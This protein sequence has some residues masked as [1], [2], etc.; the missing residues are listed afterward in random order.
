MHYD[1]LDIDSLL[2]SDKEAIIH[3]LSKLSTATSSENQSF[4]NNN[5]GGS[6]V[7]L[8]LSVQQLL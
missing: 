4:S 1:L 7:R 5:I 6:V 2:L 8:I 3:K